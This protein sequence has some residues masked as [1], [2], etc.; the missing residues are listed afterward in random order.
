MDDRT[1]GSL[2]NRAA[3]AYVAARLGGLAP[4]W[5]TW[6]SWARPGAQKRFATIVRER[7]VPRPV[8]VPG[9]REHLFRVEDLDRFIARTLK[10][11]QC[12]PTA[13]TCR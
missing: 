11:S 5:E 6:S 1:T 2:K 4:T 7:L 13:A 10:L 8:R 3:H 9:I 12:S